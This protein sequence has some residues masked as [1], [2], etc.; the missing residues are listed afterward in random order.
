[1]RILEEEG[2]PPTMILT[3]LNDNPSSSVTNMIEILAAKLIAK[4]FP[5]RFEAVGEDPVILIEHYEPRRDARRGT[6]R[7]PSYDRVTFESWAPRKV[8]LGGQERLL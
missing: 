6:R 7:K 8:W 4:H 5:I 1:M 3:E 2:K